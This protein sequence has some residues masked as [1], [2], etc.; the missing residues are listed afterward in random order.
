MP[1]VPPAVPPG[2]AS[3]CPLR[4]DGETMATWVA[5]DRRPMKRSALGILVVGAVLVVAAFAG[6]Y[7]FVAIWPGLPPW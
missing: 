5:Q 6:A 7:V 4:R 3:V 2:L 1:S